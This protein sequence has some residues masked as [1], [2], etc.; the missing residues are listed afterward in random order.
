MGR[1]EMY[2]RTLPL[3]ETPI[4]LSLASGQRIVLPGLDPVLGWLGDE[5]ARAPQPLI[6]PH[7]LLE[8][9]PTETITY[10]CNLP[11]PAPQPGRERSRSAPGPETGPAFLAASLPGGRVATVEAGGKAGAMTFRWLCVEASAAR[12][13]TWRCFVKLCNASGGTSAWTSTGL[14]YTFEAA[15]GFALDLPGSVR[16]T[17]GGVSYKIAHPGGSLTCLP[18]QSGLV[19]V[20]RLAADGWAKRELQ[21]LWLYPGRS[22]VA[23][24]S[25][26]AAMRI[27]TAAPVRAAFMAA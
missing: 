2:G 19:K 3:E 13:A 25:D 7:W 11:T 8:P 22:V 4:P 16:I 5:S 27:A 24:F 12:G 6:L 1:F 9:R 18:S 26:G 15:G 20:T 21:S 14:D 10:S 17:L 23:R